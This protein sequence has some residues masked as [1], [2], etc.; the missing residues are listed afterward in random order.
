MS[1]KHKNKRSEEK[2]GFNELSWN[3][4]NELTLLYIQLNAIMVLIYSDLMF[5]FAVVAAINEVLTKD[6]SKRDG[7]ASDTYNA[8]S[9]VIA[10]AYTETEEAMEDNLENNTLLKAMGQ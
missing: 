7:Y 4:R 3:D 8:G 1:H 10:A 9:R 2:A 6:G 5:Y